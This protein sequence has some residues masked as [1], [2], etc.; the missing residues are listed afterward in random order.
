[1][2]VIGTWEEILVIYE[3]SH[4]L[5]YPEYCMEDPT[6]YWFYMI[7]NHYQIVSPGLVN[8]YDVYIGSMCYWW[9]CPS[10]SSIDA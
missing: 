6:C 1:M 5:L 9:L 7:E 10:Q 3:V 4:G 2:A 8:E